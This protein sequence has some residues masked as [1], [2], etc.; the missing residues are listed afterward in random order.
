MAKSSKLEDYWRQ[1]NIESLLKELM[2]TLAQQMPPDPAVATVQYLQKKF[3]KSFKTSVDNTN[4]NK[5]ADIVSKT[6]ATNLQSQSIIS[7]RSKVNIENTNEINMRERR[8]S[9]Q[10]QING[11][12]TIPTVG[13]TCD[14]LLKHDTTDSKQA[15]DI[16]LTNLVSTNRLNQQAVKLGKDI[17]SYRDILEQELIKPIKTKS[18]ISSTTNASTYTI[19]EDFQREQPYVPQFIK[20]KQRIHD[21][22]ERRQHREKL[23]EIARQVR[24]KEQILQSDELQ[25]QQQQQKSHDDE[26]LFHNV[27]EKSGTKQIHKSFVKSKEEEILNDENIF[28]PRREKYRNR[29]SRSHSD[30][31]YK[32]RQYMGD[33]S[34]SMRKGNTSSMPVIQS[35]SV[36]KVC[37]SIINNDENPSKV[38]SQQVSAMQTARSFERQ[39]TT[40]S[41]ESSVGVVDDWFEPT[42]DVST[43]QQVLLSTPDDITPQVI[44]TNPFQQSRFQPIND[45]N[46]D[47]VGHRPPTT[48]LINT[49]YKTKTKQTKTPRMS[50]SDIFVKT[51][52]SNDRRSPSSRSISSPI[53]NKHQT[54]TAEVT[55]H[56]LPKTKTHSSTLATP[57]TTIVPTTQRRMSGWGVCEHS[58]DDSDEN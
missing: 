5:N 22:N 45:N 10:S 37:G 46:T 3:P 44:D 29:L 6:V 41:V 39:S 48:P 19:S 13:S 55:N 57:T 24:D 9:N 54:D 51:L 1:N 15:L 52:E 58:P 42:S 8:A 11:I 21:K 17:R 23:A 43:P 28:Q 2:Q 18:N 14:N 49:D 4:N 26:R 50:E 47:T 56:Q 20:Y 36:C 53:T 32:R 27:S 38:Y 16:N 30:A 33:F 12:F 31:P 7:P 25:Q 34:L 35:D 40:R